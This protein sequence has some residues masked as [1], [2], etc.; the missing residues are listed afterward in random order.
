VK[1]YLD[2]NV[3]V[4][5]SAE[6]HQHHA[7]SFA[8]MNAIKNGTLQGYISTHV[9][10]EFYSVITRVP[11]KPRVHPA[12]AERLLNEN[13]LPYLELVALSVDDYKSVL[14]LCANSGLG[15]AIIFDALHLQCARKAECDRI[16]TFNVKDFRALAP[17]DIAG[18]I[19]AP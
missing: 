16:Y 12:E 9:L 13:I 7:R 14:R 10:A 1:A 6:E 17:A 11:F 15:G 4:A 3:L 8:L 2:T 5:S 19:T 18:R